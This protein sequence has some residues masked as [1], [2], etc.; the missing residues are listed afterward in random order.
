[1]NVYLIRHGEAESGGFSVTDFDRRLTPHGKKLV[2]KAAE[3]WKKIIPVPELIVSSPLLRAK[4]TAEIVH[5]VFAVK[6]PISFDRLLAGNT[7][8]DSVCEM[9]NIFGV[10]SIMLFGHEPDMSH[11][12]SMMTSGGHLNAEFKKAMIARISFASRAV[13]GKGVLEYLIPARIFE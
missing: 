12:L 1:M 5:S 6:A 10:N 4:E 7:D 2:K 8:T 9:I 11:H 13:R 3:Y